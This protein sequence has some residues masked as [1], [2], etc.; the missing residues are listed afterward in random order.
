MTILTTVL[1]TMGLKPLALR[2]IDA[3][4]YS[5]LPAKQDASKNWLGLRALP[6]RAIL[7]IGA[8]KGGYARDIALRHFPDAIIHSFEPS[9]VAFADLAEIAAQSGG[10]IVAHN[11]GLGDKADR[12]AFNNVVDFIYSSSLLPIAKEG[13][14]HFPQLANVEQIMVDVVTLDSIAPSLNLPTQGDLLIKMDVQGFEDRV[15][16]GGSATIAKARACIIEVGTQILYEGQPDFDAIYTSMS[17]LGFDFVGLL[18]QFCDDA[19]KPL[20]FDA[21]FMNKRIPNG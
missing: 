13:V 14:E 4:G 2:L 15:I 9:P 11:V 6:I 21:L 17:A 3:L 18:E 8:C 1:R 10:K 7:D 20:Y 5:L 16:T 19:G 12:L